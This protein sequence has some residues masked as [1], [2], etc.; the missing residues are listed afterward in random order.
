MLLSEL[1]KIMVKKVTFVGFREVI[2]AP[3]PT[4]GV[5]QNAATNFV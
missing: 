3:G 4:L 5:K 2:A 1:H